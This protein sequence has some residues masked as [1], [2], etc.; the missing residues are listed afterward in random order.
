[1]SEAD[2]AASSLPPLPGQPPGVPWPTASWPRASLD[3]ARSAVTR[4][5]DGLF[6]LPEGSGVSYAVLLIQGGKLLYERYAAGAN[7]FYLQYSWSMAKS[8]THALVGIAVRQGRL[9]P[10]APAAVPEWQKAD[11][12]RRHITVDQ[13]LRMRSGLAFNEDYLDG[14]Q[15]DV[16]P[17]LSFEG[18]HDTGAFAAG[19]PLLHPP[20]EVFSYSSGTTNIIA[21]IL[22]ELIGGPG[23]MLRFMADE[24]F[25]PIGMRTPTPR[26]DSA[27]TFIGSSFLF[28][29]PQDFARFG[30]LYLRDGVWDGQ[31]IL[32]PGWADYARTPSYQ[33]AEA[34][35]GAH[36]WLQQDDHRR[37]CASGYDGQRILVAPDKDAVALRLGRTDS[38]HIA[39]LWVRLNAAVSAL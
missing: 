29:T 5:L 6:D 3:Q 23:E 33:D 13:L 7:A 9:D 36:W 11:D 2:S 15:S 35:Y 12:P 34:A 27:G 21:R 14:A 24:L 26:F 4:E 1:M 22:R 10:L 8:V 19:K 38:E 17:M 30:Y 20:G 37:F 16:I 39:P 31:R 28:A 32:P 25:E 18:R